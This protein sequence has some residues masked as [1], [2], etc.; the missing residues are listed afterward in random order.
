[1]AHDG[2]ASTTV[3]A[4]QATGMKVAVILSLIHI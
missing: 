4:G 1:M 3:D 2:L